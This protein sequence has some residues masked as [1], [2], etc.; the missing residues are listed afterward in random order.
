MVEKVPMTPRGAE[1][2]K[3]ELARLKEERPK[4]SREIGVAREHG[5][6]SENAEY[7]AAKERQGL[8]EARIKDLE[9]KLSRSEVIDPSSLSGDKVRFGATVTLLNVETEEES[10]YQ[11]VGADEADL[12]QGTIS[13]SA[14][15][16]RALIG[17]EAGD[18]IKVQLPGG[19]RHYEIV[20]VEFS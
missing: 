19:A 15:L 7:H 5:D 18:E 12:N 9:D 4:I 20:G 17:K 10:T 8:V 11:I 16:A 6:L 1:K 13:I 14:P 3:E 2:L